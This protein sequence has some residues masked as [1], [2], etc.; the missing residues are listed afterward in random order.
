[1][2]DRPAKPAPAVNDAD[3]LWRQRQR[4]AFWLRQFHTW[5]WVS[6]AM[7]LIGMI[8]FAATGI[9]LNHAGQ[10]ETRPK[11]ETRNADLPAAM[12][13]L[14]QAGPQTAKQAPLPAEVQDF[15]ASRLAVGVKDRDTEWSR[16]E[17][18]VALPRAGGD[19]WLSIDRADGKITYEATD[20]GWIAYFNDLHK[21]RHTGAA[22][23][24][25][26]D[27]FAAACLVFCLTGLLLLNFHASRRPATWPM[28]G[29]GLVIPFLL[30][31]LFVHQ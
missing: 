26:I 23:R 22:W 6:S 28:V 9:T 20:R 8:L 25:F 11:V 17:I 12:L 10:I 27:I 3:L 31:V 30:L 2:H 21:G 29:L 14:V 19:A 7:C 16:D 13:A 1:M 18:Y 15:I 4:R 5:H 24:W